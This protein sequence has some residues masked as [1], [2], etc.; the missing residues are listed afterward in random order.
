MHN[1]IRCPH[2]AGAMK[3]SVTTTTE[4]S[5]VEPV[6]EETLEYRTRRLL[7]E[8]EAYLA[9]L[10][11]K[12]RQAGAAKVGKT[13]ERIRTLRETLNLDPWTGKPKTPEAQAVDDLLESG[14][15]LEMDDK[16]PEIAG[17]GALRKGSQ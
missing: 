12:G 9:V 3:V 11:K 2:C 7:G 10:E 15:L 16:G 4:I 14:E 8:A 17:P 1:V 6:V 13:Q 5:S